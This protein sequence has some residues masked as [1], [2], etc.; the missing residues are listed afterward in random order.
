MPKRNFVILIGGPGLYYAC[1]TAHDKTWSNYVVPMQ[2]A[3]KEK[4]YRL[5]AEKV[6]WLVFAPAYRKR[7]N[8]DSNI[9]PSERNE[10]G[11]FGRDRISKKRELHK[12]DTWLHKHRKQEAE[13]V[14]AKHGPKG[15]PAMS[16]LNRISQI[17]M[18]HNITFQTVEKPS[19]FWTYLSGLKNGSI[20]RVWY[21]GHAAK[22]G[23][24]IDLDHNINSTQCEAVSG[25]IITTQDIR[26]H[27]SAIKPKISADIDKTS[28][29]YGCNTAE[30]AK[31]WNQQFEVTTEG[32]DSKITFQAIYSGN[33]AKNIL[34]RLRTHP[35]NAG[36]PKWRKFIK[37]PRVGD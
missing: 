3:A 29:F 18:A 30:F 13:K 31:V 15:N 12:T 17:C 16:Y 33:P 27:S 34:E 9:T 35:T 21:C 6:H 37:T 14:K 24:F 8:D 2:L 4:L 28:E 10:Y 1:D 25:N 5:E 36:S 32:A 7:W 20:S 19:D 11:W 23:L 26:I 22:S